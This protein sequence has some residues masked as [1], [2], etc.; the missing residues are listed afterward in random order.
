MNSQPKGLRAIAI[1]EA[2]KGLL[3]LVVGLALH[4]LGGP[5]IQA[6]CE[7]LLQH[8]RMNPAGEI[9]SVIHEALA[10]VDDKNLT[11][12]AVG[13]VL[14]ASVR[15]IEAFGLW[16]GYAWTEWFA[17]ASGAIYVPFEVYEVFTTGKVLPILALVTNLII[18]GYMALVIAKR[19]RETKVGT[20]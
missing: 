6:I 17:L 14:Y 11:I 8:L 13:T 9:P 12:L 10:N 16:R 7:A 19:R 18:I 4:E 15:L 5:K 3:A 20:P 1:L 2:S